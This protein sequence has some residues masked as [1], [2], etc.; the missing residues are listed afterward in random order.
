MESFGQGIQEAGELLHGS[1]AH[2]VQD[3][4]RP[5]LAGH[6]GAGWFYPPVGVLP[7]AGQAVPEDAGVFVG[8][9]VGDG[10]A[11]EHPVVQHP[12]GR[13]G[14]EQLLLPVEAGQ[15]RRSRLDLGHHGCGRVLGCTQQKGVGVGVVAEAMALGHGPPGQVHPLVDQTVPDHEEGG[16][17]SPLGQL[18]EDGV[19]HAGPRPV[20]EGETYDRSRPPLVGHRGSSPYP[21]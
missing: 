11:I 21:C 4:H 9:E 13:V 12:S 19:G 17:Q 2:V 8:D 3:D 1:G 15:P 18:V 7:V 5:G 10:G 20:V 16:G 6:V 14:A